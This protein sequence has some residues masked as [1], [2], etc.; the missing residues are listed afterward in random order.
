MIT[1]V[2]IL[3]VLLGVGVYVIW[4]LMRKVERLEDTANQYADYIYNITDVIR[5]MDV[6]VREIDQRGTFEADDEIGFFFTE[7]KNM[8]NI[9]NSI[10]INESTYQEEER[11]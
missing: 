5:E 9:L 8:Q 7:L 6:R 2:V 10:N 11:S 1:A 3:S 4:N